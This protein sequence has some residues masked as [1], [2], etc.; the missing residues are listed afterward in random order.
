MAIQ[1]FVFLFIFPYE[2]PKYLFEHN[3]LDKATSLIHM[4]YNSD[5]I[6]EAISQYRT[7]T[8]VEEV[9]LRNSE[10]ALE[11]TENRVYTTS[12]LAIFMSLYLPFTKQMTGINAVTIYGKEALKPIVSE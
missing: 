10:I 6:E 11:E 3:L 2:T 7:G 4:I 8:V 9:S 1:S 5:H 12:K